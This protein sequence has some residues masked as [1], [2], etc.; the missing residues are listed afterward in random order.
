MNANLRSVTDK[1]QRATQPEDVF[2][3]LDQPQDVALSRRYRFLASVVHPDH[4][5]GAQQAAEDAFKLLQRWYDA[6]NAKLSQGSYGQTVVIELRS[7]KAHYV[8]TTAPIVGDLSDV[9]A[10]CADS[11]RVLVKLGRLPRNNDLMQAEARALR[12]IRRELAG[13]KT[14]AHFPELFDSFRV[15]DTANVQRQANVL[16][17]GPSG[18]AFV[19]LADV[20]ARYPTGVHPAD[21]AWMFNRLL[22]ALAKTHEMGLVHG[23]VL[24]VHVLIRPKDHNGQLIDWCY[25]V[26]NG[27]TIKAISPGHRPFYPNEVLAKR[28]ATPATDLY[29]AAM[30]MLALL[31]GDVQTQTLPA[32]VPKPVAAMLRGCLIASQHYRSGDAWE[33]FD[34]FQTI[35]RR[36]YGAPT[37]RPFKM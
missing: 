10:V 11:E 32:S 6:A 13:D 28:P 25:S 26:E 35:L 20:M 12:T 31:G 9:Y 21:A 29:M 5:M 16:R 24:P 17:H 36:L 18:S 22:V 4:N 37:F 27:G 1:L 34:Q 30:T 14:L 2:G 7:S 15:R 33:L 19:T 3:T 8:G 23:A